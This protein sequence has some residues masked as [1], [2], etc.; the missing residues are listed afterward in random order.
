M[1]DESVDL[2]KNEDI[3]FLD[4]Y[5]VARLL[6]VDYTTIKRWRTKGFGPVPRRLNFPGGRRSH[7]RYLKHEVMEF[8]KNLPTY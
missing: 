4:I 1:K 5:E 6:R 8:L 7:L 3:E 2:K